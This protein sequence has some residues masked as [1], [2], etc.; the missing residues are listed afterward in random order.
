M[1]LTTK[2]RYGTRLVLDL[3]MYGNDGPVPLSEI[4][5]RQNISLKYLEQLVA[6]LKKAGYITSQRGP[7]G[8]HMLSKKPEEI[9][10]SDIVMVLEGTTSITECS[11]EK[12]KLCGVCNK[13]GDCLSQWVW[14]EASKAM[15]D[16]LDEITIKTLLNRSSESHI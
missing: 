2:S 7:F 11:E 14:I 15:F 10:I 4:A 8:G 13:A 6:K 12:N 3:A 1:R 5:K 16:R 9:T